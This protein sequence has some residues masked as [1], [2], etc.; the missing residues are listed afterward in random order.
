MDKLSVIERDALEAKLIRKFGRTFTAQEQRI[1]DALDRNPNEVLQQGFWDQED[2]EFPWLISLLAAGGLASYLSSIP[3]TG[4][5]SSGPTT[6]IVSPPAGLMD[7]VRLYA[8]DLVQGINRTSADRLAEVMNLWHRGEL[9]RQGLEEAISGIFPQDR[10]ARIGV[11]ETTRAQSLGQDAAREYLEAEGFEVETI[12]HA[13]E[14]ACE[15]ICRPL[16]GQVVEAEDMPPLHI[17]CR[18]A[19]TVRWVDPR[20][21]VTWEHIEQFVDERLKRDRLAS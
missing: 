21:T 6:G 16:D 18:C 15:E 13:A 11:T 17:G 14:D 20:K 9:N 1:L 5:V 12:F 4:I 10:A 2:H 3:I 8:F 7:R 19:S